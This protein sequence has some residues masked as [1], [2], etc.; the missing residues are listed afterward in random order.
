MVMK[1]I[2]G[3][4]GFTHLSSPEKHT[5]CASNNDLHILVS[6]FLSFGH[7]S[8]CANDISARSQKVAYFR[9][10]QKLPKQKINHFQGSLLIADTE[11][12]FHFLIFLGHLPALPDYV[13]V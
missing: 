10:G 12:I 5:E 2:L 13:I 1:T 11:N 3:R 8:N 9:G 7:E 6:C 4:L